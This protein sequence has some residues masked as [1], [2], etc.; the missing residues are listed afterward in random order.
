M[1]VNVPSPFDDD[2]DLSSPEGIR[3]AMQHSYDW[4]YELAE[5]STLPPNTSQ[6]EAAMYGVLSS[7]YEETGFTQLDTARN[8]QLLWHDLLPFLHLPDE[9]GLEALIEYII[10]KEP[11][12]RDGARKD[13]LANKV[14]RGTA[15][16]L[17]DGWDTEVRQAMDIGGFGPLPWIRLIADGAR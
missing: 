15:N 12:T 9:T 8:E 2:P 11:D 7:F 10:W 3:T 6:H 4:H 1:M 5:T 14:Q 16:A 13:W 17:E